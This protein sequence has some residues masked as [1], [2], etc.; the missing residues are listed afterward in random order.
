MNENL[1]LQAVIQT[2][3]EEMWEIVG[4]YNGIEILKRVVIEVDSFNDYLFV[5]RKEVAT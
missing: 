3:Q 4:E 1:V 5:D 2:T